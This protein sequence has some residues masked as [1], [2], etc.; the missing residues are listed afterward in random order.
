[1]EQH[2]PDTHNKMA[3][4]KKRKQSI[5][6]VIRCDFVIVGRKEGRKKGTK[7]SGWEGTIKR[8]AETEEES[9]S[10]GAGLF[11]RRQQHH[12]GNKH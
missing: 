2:P 8:G 7:V 12:H 6:F 11:G 3:K 4:E 5:A 9:G 10:G 1:M